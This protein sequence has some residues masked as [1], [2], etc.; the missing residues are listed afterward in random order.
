MSTRGGGDE[1]EQQADIDL[2]FLRVCRGV[3]DNAT[4]LVVPLLGW[5]K[6]E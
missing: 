4:V 6:S 5:G 2:D 1:R 3:E